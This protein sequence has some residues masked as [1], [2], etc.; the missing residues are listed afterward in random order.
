MT[1]HLDAATVEPLLSWQGVIDAIVDGHSRD[2]HQVDDTLLRRGDDS[3]LSRA[4]LIDGL[5]SLVKTATVFPANATAGLPAVNGTVSLFSDTTGEVDATIDFH[6]LTKWKTA[7]DSA[8]A[9]S[10]LARPDTEQILIVGSGAVAAS[11]VDAY[12]SV[13]P[14]ARVT[15]WS[16]THENAVRLA[17]STGAA[18]TNDLIAAVDL[19]DVICTATMATQPVLEGRWLRDGQHVDLIGGYRTDM[20]ETDDDAISKAS[21]FVDSKQSAMDV[22][23]IITPISD[24]VITTQQL[25]DFGGI[26]NGSFARSSENEITICKNAG[27]AHLDLMVARHMH[28]LLTDSR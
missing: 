9:A 14:D 22:G 15:I 25:V 27:G 12:R 16:R 24:K 20:R 3:L 1:V 8:L 10:R 13:F 2:D 19:A 26:S 17:E 5:G 4:A 21:I 6:L 23:D 28:G 18:A 7:A 11:M